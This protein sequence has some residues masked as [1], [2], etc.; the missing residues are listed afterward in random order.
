MLNAGQVFSWDIDTDALDIAQSNIE[1]FDLDS[2]TNLICCDLGES[3][4]SYFLK[5]LSSRKII[6]TVVMNPPFGTKNKG[7]Y[8]FLT[9]CFLWEIKCHQISWF[10]LSNADKMSKVYPLL[11]VN[12]SNIMIKFV[13]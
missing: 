8:V 5:Y 11:D 7:I 10:T 13:K 1:D 12:S 3:S 6:D 4:T 9:R 2:K